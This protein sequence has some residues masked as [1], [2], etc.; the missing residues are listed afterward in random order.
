MR[1]S[2][3]EYFSPNLNY[4]KILSIEE[5]Y[6]KLAVRNFL[7]RQLNYYHWLNGLLRLL[8]CFR[9]LMSFSSFCFICIQSLKRRWINKSLN[10][11][12]WDIKLVRGWKLSRNRSWKLWALERRRSILACFHWIY[13]FVR[14]AVFGDQGLNWKNRILSKI[15]TQLL[16]SLQRIWS[17]CK[18]N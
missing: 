18:M 17:N 13:V 8:D 10:Y 15:F 1:L 9:L 7:L 16:I 3:K 5:N 12:I 2:H 14:R 4:F 6:S 11:L